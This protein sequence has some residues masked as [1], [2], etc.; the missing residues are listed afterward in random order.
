MRTE[1]SEK[2]SV[3]NSSEEMN[4]KEQRNEAEPEASIRIKNAFLKQEK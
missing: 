4:F 1:E 3:Y 2:G